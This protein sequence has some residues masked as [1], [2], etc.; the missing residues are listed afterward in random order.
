VRITVT[1]TDQIE[2]CLSC[3]NVNF[4]CQHLGRVHLYVLGKS[5]SFVSTFSLSG[6]YRNNWISSTSWSKKVY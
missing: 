3:F 1:D 2:M 4:Q 5:I 6:E